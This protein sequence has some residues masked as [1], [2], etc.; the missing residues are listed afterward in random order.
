MQIGIARKCTTIKRQLESLRHIMREKGSENLTV[1]GH[2]DGIANRYNYAEM[3]LKNE[4]IGKYRE[5]M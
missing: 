3:Y 4:Y 2:T 5:R 1:A